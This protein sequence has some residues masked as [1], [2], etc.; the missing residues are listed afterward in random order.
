MV[1]L[2]E[3]FRSNLMASDAVLPPNNNA[4]CSSLAE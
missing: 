4:L 3:M 2:L 1:F